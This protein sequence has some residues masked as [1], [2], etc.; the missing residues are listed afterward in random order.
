MLALAYLAILMFAGDAIGRR[1]FSYVSWPHRVATAFLIGLPLGAWLS[2][3]VAAGL[4]DIGDPLLV[5]NVV[6]AALLGALAWFLRRR[7]PSPIVRPAP[8][9]TARS[10]GWDRL[11]IGLLL[12]VVSW[13]MLLTYSFGDG[14][15]GIAGG[16]WSDFGPTTA[17]SQSFAL[18]HNLPTEYPHFA[19]ESIRYH[20]MFYFQVG[21]LTHLGIDPALALNVLSIGTMLAMLILVMALGER[22]FRSA[23]VGRIGAILFFLHGSLSFIPFLG[24][25]GSIGQALDELPR[26][27]PFVSSGFPW[28][29]EEW[30]IWT[31]MVFLNQ[32][33][34]AGAL[35]ML[36]VIVLF[37]L[38]RLRPVDVEPA[39][40]AEP[41]M[42]VP[43]LRT[44]LSERWS[45]AT[46]RLRRTLARPGVVVR[47][48]LEDPALP[49]YAVCG[50][51]A[52]MLPLWNG[53]IFVAAFALLGVWF[54]VFPNRPQMIVLAIAAA[55][56]AIPQLLVRAARND[57]RRAG[58]PGVPL[59][60]RARGRQ[61]RECRLVPGVHLRAQAAP[62][63]GRPRPG[64][65]AA[66]AGVPRVHL[67]RR[68]RV[69]HP[70]QRRGPR[71]P[72]V[73]QCLAHRRESL[74]RGGPAAAVERAGRAA[75]ARPARRCRALARHRDR[76]RHRLHAGQEPAGGRGRDGRRCAVR[77]G[78]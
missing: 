76:R 3:L 11:V 75:S 30:G 51:V 78:A 69:P 33:H 35:G 6:A 36:L 2:Y 18:G 38:D 52:G 50:L 60:L 43:P 32:R 65:L 55:I 45:G 41:P 71:Q 74:R 68:C 27:E 77:V 44:R 61:P 25:Y 48:T 47:E 72:Q 8:P 12:L 23:A 5:A 37:L 7:A 53:S 28:R 34:L 42:P 4:G 31:Q 64:Q 59:G 10:A 70:A 15:L 54:V 40:E 17:I 9:R 58:L 21:N 13:M 56:P 16:V 24:R 57:G 49:G 26:L 20:F 73:H 62:H 1:W 63:R 14:R 22:L 39:V 46:K 66:V 19:G 67:A 29:G